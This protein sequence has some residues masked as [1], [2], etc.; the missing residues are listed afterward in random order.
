MFRL[1]W[2]LLVALALDLG[3]AQPNVVLQ[4]NGVMIDAIRVDNS[5]PTVSSRN[6]AILHTAIFDA[7]NSIAR[8]HQPY[9]GFVAT[10]GEASLE[11]A[12]VAAAHA[13]T[14]SLYPG[15]TS[16][17]DLLRDEFLAR[18]PSTPAMSHG[19][20][21]GTEV[22]R[23]ALTSREFDGANVEVPY[24]PETSAGAW[25]RT[26]PFFRPPVTPHWRYV[27]PFG[28]DDL[29][30]YVP[31]PPPPLSSAAYA[32]ALAEVKAL[33][34]KTSTARTA[35]QAQTAVF[36]SD[37]SYTSMPPGHW[38][39]LT[40]E[41]ARNREQSLVET[42]R[43]FAL[44]SIAQADA[45]ILCWEAKYRYNLWR[46]ITAIRQANDD[47]NP[48]TEV[49]PTWDH[50]LASPPFPSYTSGHSTFSKASAE[51]LARFYG[52]DAI[53]FTA[54]SDSLP[55]VTRTFTSLA[56]CADEIGMSRIYGGIHFSFDNIE[57]KRSGQR[58]GEFVSQN[59]LLPVQGLPAL[60]MEA[61]SSDLRIR[62]HAA[63]DA[64]AVLESS[65]DLFQWTPISTNHATAGGALVI[66][67]TDGPRQ[68]FR[69]RN[70]H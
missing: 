13:V 61:R 12:A 28:I 65:V 33:G 51:V 31:P 42:A 47:G 22:A 54:T 46:P 56:A 43:L 67:A 24:I 9:R 36:W 32:A 4:W 41:I 53:T 27:T 3:A 38:H 62:I 68:F 52:T 64:A 66:Q 55:G 49:E 6:L 2:L 57:G 69:V 17:A 26:A 59:Y 15:I 39:L 16:R 63:G 5:G 50:L 19:W 60:T 8:T 14:T 37:F 35:Y 23:R 34:G 18:H 1:F 11:A 10:N 44:L 70:E 7:V 58:I 48:L 45:A 21:V 25:R 29:E 40:A 20:E 30:F